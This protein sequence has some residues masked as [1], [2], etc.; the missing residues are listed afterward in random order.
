MPFKNKYMTRVEWADSDPLGQT[1][2]PHYFRW[3]DIGTHSLLSA[4]GKPYNQLIIDWNIAGLPLVDAQASFRSRCRW[5]D[6][7][8]VESY[9]SAFGKKS[10]TVSHNIMNGTDIAVEGKEV[11]IWGLFDP[12]DSS[13]LKA[14]LIPED[15]KKIF[16]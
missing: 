14:G 9:I 10:F 6:Q 12:S 7:I 15:F 4:A 11:R 5:T 2:Y 3:F 8:E 16:S 13:K 1:F